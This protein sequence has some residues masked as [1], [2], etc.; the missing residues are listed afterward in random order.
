M[1]KHYNYTHLIVLVLLPSLVTAASLRGRVAFNSKLLKIAVDDWLQNS[2]VACLKYGGDI[3]EWDISRVY[4]MSHLFA[5]AR[6]FDG[7]LS[8][9]NTTNV[10]DFSYVFANASSFTGDLARW[11][12]SNALSMTHMFYGASSFNS[13]LAQWNT[14]KVMDFS[15]MFANAQSF[16][17][18]VDNF[19]VT[20]SYDLSYMFYNASSFNRDISDW[21][22]EDL[23]KTGFRAK[24]V[25]N[26]QS[27]FQLAS[28]FNGNLTGWQTFAVVNMH[29]MF[30]NATR[31]SGVGL[32]NWNVKNVKDF[33]EMFQGSTVSEDLCWDVNDSALTNDMLGGSSIS[34]SNSCGEDKERVTPYIRLREAV[35]SGATRKVKLTIAAAAT[36]ILSLM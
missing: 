16:N 27:M 17:G 34:L 32:S 25:Q 30:K 36:I 7:D 28:T 3:S 5:N 33:R 23:D 10:R 1:S 6:H 31:Y 12:T 26:M 21:T 2:T 18:R 8:R 9:W 20:N 19:D 13:D 4:N 15:Y 29:S 24:W 11:D 22:R 14:T 35:P